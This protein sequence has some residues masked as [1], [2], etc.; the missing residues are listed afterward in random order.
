M[1]WLEGWWGL[2]YAYGTRMGVSWKWGRRSE[3][4]MV[5]TRCGLRVGARL[6]WWL[7]TQVWHWR[8]APNGSLPLLTKLGDLLVLFRSGHNLSR[9]IKEVSDKLSN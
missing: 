4:S 8:R 9:L 5:K 2:A 7:R 3:R 6:S 1:S